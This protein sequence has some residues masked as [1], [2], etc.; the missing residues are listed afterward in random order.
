VQLEGTTTERSEMDA[1][2]AEAREPVE[3]PACGNVH[4]ECSDAIL[5]GMDMLARDEADKRLSS[6]GK[7]ALRMVQYAADTLPGGADEAWYLAE[8]VERL[9][10]NEIRAIKTYLART[11]L[12]DAARKWVYEAPAHD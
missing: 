3:C 4:P 6:E 7:E 11:T 10:E 2:N 12:I 8:S 5:D 1:P 9:P